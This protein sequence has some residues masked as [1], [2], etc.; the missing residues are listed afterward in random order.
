MELQELSP[1]ELSELSRRA[2]AIAERKRRESIGTYRAELLSK[3][4]ADGYTLAD[5][6]LDGGKA[7]KVRRPARPKYR[8][9]ANP[10]Q[11]WT[12]RGKNPNW[13]RD[14]MSV[15]YTLEQMLIRS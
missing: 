12:G 2:A 13:V 15:G 8:N 5:L 1:S 7:E 9:P 10:Q 6:G 4:K 14:A 11:T 3:I